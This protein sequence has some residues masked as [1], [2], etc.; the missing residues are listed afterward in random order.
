M[1][2]HRFTQ[3]HLELSVPQ[4]SFSPV[5]GAWNLPNRF[6]RPDEQTN[7]NALRGDGESLLQPNH[8]L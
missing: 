5:Q 7:G 3:I 1:S 4:A 2:L 6:R 8:L